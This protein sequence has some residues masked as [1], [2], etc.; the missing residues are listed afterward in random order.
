MSSHGEPGGD[1]GHAS[2]AAWAIE[3][4]P[5]ARGLYAGKRPGGISVHDDTLAAPLE[6]VRLRRAERPGAGAAVRPLVVLFPDAKTVGDRGRRA[7]EWL[8][9]SLARRL[10]LSVVTVQIPPSVID[11]QE[12]AHQ[13]LLAAVAASGSD[14]I[15]L[16][17]VGTG[18]ALAAR[19]AMRVRDAGSPALLRQA[20]VSPDFQ[21]VVGPRTTT[22]ALHTSLVARVSELP[23]T[24]IQQYGDRAAGRLDPSQN[25]PELLQESGVAVRAIAYPPSRLDWT[26]YPRAVRSSTRALDDLVAFLERG[27]VADG[28]DVVPAWNLH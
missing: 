4:V 17:G 13:A 16:I 14:K 9:G 26:E 2:V 11:D 20:L 3:H 25:L 18:G 1:T 12:A 7:G 28:F 23:P 10:P 19:T 15:A 24:L 22:D 5:F 6:A 27:I 21:L 8:A